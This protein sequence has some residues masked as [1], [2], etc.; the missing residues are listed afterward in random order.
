MPGKVWKNRVPQGRLRRNAVFS[1]PCGTDGDTSQTPAFKRRAI[2]RM[3]LRDT[4]FSVVQKVSCAPE[5]RL[6]PA[7]APFLPCCRVNAAFLSEVF[8]GFGAGANLRP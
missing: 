1:R 8:G 3:S 4:A 2:F 6:Q 5:R 7:E